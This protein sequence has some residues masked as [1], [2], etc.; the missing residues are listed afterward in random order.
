MTLAL[1]VAVPATLACPWRSTREQ[2]VLGVAVVVV[3]VV[4]AWWRGVHL[5]TI[6]GRRLAM[7]RRRRR[8]GHRRSGRIAGIDVQTTALIRIRPLTANPDALPL[9]L[10]AGYLNRYG[11]RAERIRITNH[12]IETEIW[13]TWIGLTVSAVDNLAALQARSSRIPLHQTTQVAARRLAEQLREVGWAASTAE[14]GDVP[15]L[16][17]RSARESWRGVVRETATGKRDCV[18][19]YRISVD[20]ALPE[21]LAAIRCHPARETWTALE[22]AG[23]GTGR[24]LAAACAFRTS[25]EPRGAPPPGLVP[26]HGNHRAALLALN[27]LSIQRL[28]GHTD[29]PGDLLVRLRWP[30]AVRESAHETA[31]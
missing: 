4:L 18:A 13:E 9:P 21:T 22:I 11:I 1:L 23:N 10:I 8:F 27:P 29:L 14:P 7:S 12:D 28:D 26:Q 31:F 24:T 16:V 25:A 6:L 30:T 20:D 17:A 2:W 19:A 15:P 3:I 5:T